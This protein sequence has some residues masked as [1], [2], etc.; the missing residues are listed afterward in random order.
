MDVSIIIVNYNSGDFLYNCIKSIQKNIKNIDY[1]IIV[2]DNNSS[3]NS[4]D[5]CKELLDEKTNVV[6]LKENLG[7]SKANNIGMK[8]SKGTILHFLNP[9]TRI[10]SEINNDYEYILNDVRSG[11]EMIYSNK[12]LNRDGSFTEK[13]IIPL[14]LAMIR[15][16]LKIN[17]EHDFYYIGA[18]VI[19]SKKLMKK[20]GGWNEAMFMY[21]EDTDLYYKAYLNKIQIKQMPATIYHYGGA[22]SEKEFTNISRIMIIQK[23]LRA[24]Y[25]TNNICIIKYW[26]VVLILCIELIIYKKFKNL[27]VFIRGIIKSFGD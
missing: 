3:D 25:R 1:E 10:D 26:I 23:S 5:F 16:I 20:L 19:L 17:K 18:S 8:C 24:F 27:P 12:L 11:I 14:P 4:L 22:S 13:D 7:F 6:N 21:V 15:H 2:V 9:D